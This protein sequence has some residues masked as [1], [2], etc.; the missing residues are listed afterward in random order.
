[1]RLHSAIALMFFLIPIMA[2]ASHVPEHVAGPVIQ[3]TEGLSWDANSESDMSGYHLF[4]ARDANP[5]DPSIVI[6]HSPG[7]RITVPCADAG[8]IDDGQYRFTVD[9]FDLGGLISPKSPEYAFF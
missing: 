3:C 6:S 8:V 4:I 7:G 1:M 2:H 5:Y 9:A